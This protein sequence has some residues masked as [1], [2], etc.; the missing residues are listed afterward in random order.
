MRRTKTADRHRLARDL[1]CYHP[2]EN[3]SRISK[4]QVVL[5]QAKLDRGLN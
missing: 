3:K 1:H 2:I 5:D 4:N